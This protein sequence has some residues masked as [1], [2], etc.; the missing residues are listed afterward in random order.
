VPGPVAARRVFV[1]AGTPPGVGDALRDAGWVT[2]TGLEP[3]ADEAAEA[4]R[5]GCGYVLMGRNPVPVAV[6]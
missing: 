4:A 2:V 3:V 1:P 6:P 5:L